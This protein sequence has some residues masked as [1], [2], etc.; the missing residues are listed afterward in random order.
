MCIMRPPLPPP[1]PPLIAAAAARASLLSVVSSS[2]D[3]ECCDGC[4][5]LRPALALP[6]AAVA[7]SHASDWSSGLCRNSVTEKSSGYTLVLLSLHT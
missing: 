4:C 5:C 2:L 7:N 3:D 6:T 1:P